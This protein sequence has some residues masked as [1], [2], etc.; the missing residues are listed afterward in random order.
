[1]LIAIGGVVN[2]IIKNVVQSKQRRR[3]EIV[4]ILQEKWI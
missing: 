2:Q 1:M 4:Y 3:V